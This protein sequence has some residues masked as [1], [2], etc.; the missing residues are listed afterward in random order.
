MPYSYFTVPTKARSPLD[1]SAHGGGAPG[2]VS[3][4]LTLQSFTNFAAMA[5]A[6]SAAWHAARQ[7]DA[8]LG[9]IWVPYALAGLWGVI[10]FVMS[11]PG[12]RKEGN[13]GTMLAAAFIALV[14]ALVLAG[15]VVGTD[16]AFT[17]TPGTTVKTAER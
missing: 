11:W 9:A 17:G 14:N 4:F 8:G 5:G 16:L 2:A 15:A 1:A 10:S 13:A 6:I 3:N 7:L 12:L